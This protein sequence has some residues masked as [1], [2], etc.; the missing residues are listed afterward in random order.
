[1]ATLERR[2]RLKRWPRWSSGKKLLMVGIVFLINTPV[3]VVPNVHYLISC[4]CLSLSG[5]SYVRVVLFTVLACV[6]A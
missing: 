6:R 5:V 3:S 1:M 2:Q 4:T